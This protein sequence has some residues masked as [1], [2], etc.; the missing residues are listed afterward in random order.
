MV[1]YFI[2]LVVSATGTE[3]IGQQH[4]GVWSG[5]KGISHGTGYGNSRSSQVWQGMV[6]VMK[7][8]HDVT[9]V[10]VQK[11]KHQE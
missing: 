6:L 9:I 4:Y 11:Q 2:F 1:I 3:W 10:K 5:L 8:G 7:K